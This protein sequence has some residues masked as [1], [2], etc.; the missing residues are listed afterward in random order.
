MHEIGI[1]IS[2]GINKLQ[3]LLQFMIESLLIM[4]LAFVL[5]FGVAKSVVPVIGENV[6]SSISQQQKA[7]SE[8]ASMSFSWP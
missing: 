3:I 8:S 7:A 4:V 1:L 6:K 2:I 5:S